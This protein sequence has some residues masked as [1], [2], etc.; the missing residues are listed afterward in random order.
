MVYRVKEAKQ[1]LKEMRLCRL[2]LCFST[3]EK[4]E[5]ENAFFQK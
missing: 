1:G 3:S 2:I 5:Q 4:R